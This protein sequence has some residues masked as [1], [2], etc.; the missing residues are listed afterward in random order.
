MSRSRTAAVLALG[1]AAAASFAAARLFF[2]PRPAARVPFANA[3]TDL[4]A[5]DVQSALQELS[6]RVKTV[7]SGHA[8]LKTAASVLQ[9]QV[10]NAQSSQAAQEIRIQGH[11]DR[12]GALEERVAEAL[13]A[14]RRLDY[15]DGASTSTVGPGYVQL[16]DLGTFTKRH[17]ASS[18]TL[19][20]STHVDALGE[21]GTFCDF[22]LRVD[23][24]PDSD[25]DGGG[26]RAVVYVAA[27]EQGSSAVSV[28]TL[29][30]RVG[31]GS[32]TVGVFVRGS[33]RECL[34]NYGNFPRS[35]LVEEGPRLP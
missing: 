17:P 18:V 35:V 26:G 34:E 31:P 21:P 20:W 14:R 30:S 27:G 11:G 4:E 32:H 15:G 8:S 24:K 25:R 3:G 29:F 28:S 1:V 2:G 7:E 9:Q 23:G 13:G 10:S 33:A 16:R 12:V 5:T 22:Q 6:A 19:L